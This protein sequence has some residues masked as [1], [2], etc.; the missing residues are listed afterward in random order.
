MRTLPW[1]HFMDQTLNRLIEE[2]IVSCSPHTF[3][4][5]ITHISRS[6]L[7]MKEGE[8]KKKNYIAVLAVHISIDIENC[9]IESNKTV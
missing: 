8:E 6:Q 5:N 2:I 9:F 4:S 3:I 1:E 7:L